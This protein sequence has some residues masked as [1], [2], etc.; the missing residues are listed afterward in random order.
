MRKH[1]MAALVLAVTIGGS[2]CSATGDDRAD[3]GKP[4]VAT[5]RTATPAAT[6]PAPPT[7][8]RPRARLDDTDEDTRARYA[9]YEKCM[10]EHG[11]DIRRT[12]AE[13]VTSGPIGAA[14]RA[15]GNLL[16]LPPWE[17][18]PANPEA[19]DFARDVVAC[20]KEKGV[21]YVE[22]S[23]DGPGWSLGGE[24]ND[25]ESISKGMRFSPECE[26]AAAAKRK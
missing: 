16:P 2:G 12:R 24:H 8:K 21:R 22:V 25:A 20:L 13:G 7:D 1:S 10:T 15:C 17:L 19:K 23:T 11:V 4:D 18:D 26:R 6:T 14:N 9:P 5:L 3:A